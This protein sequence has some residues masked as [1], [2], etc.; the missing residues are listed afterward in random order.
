MNKVTFLT[1]GALVVSS[2]LIAQR[3]PHVPGSVQRSFQRDYPEARD[4]QWT[5]A[6][7]S[8]HANFE[9]HSRYDRGEMVANYDRYGNH[10]DSYVPYDNNDVP[11]EVIDRTRRN[12]PDGRDYTYTRIERPHGRP[13]FQISLNLRNVNRTIYT[14]ERGHAYRYHGRQ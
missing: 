4:Q 3:T 8:W 14:D 10:I 2:Q 1:L 11:Q 6:H 7:R 9:D 13:L 5:F 12:Y